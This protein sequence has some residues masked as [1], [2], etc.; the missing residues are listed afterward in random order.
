MVGSGSDFE[1]LSRLSPQSPQIT[2]AQVPLWANMGQPALKIPQLELFPPGNPSTCLAQVW[3]TWIAACEISFCFS[4]TSRHWGILNS[5][6]ICF[7]QCRHL[8]LHI[9]ESAPH[10]HLKGCWSRAM[11]PIQ[12]W[13]RPGKRSIRIYRLLQT[14]KESV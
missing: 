14:K 5:A 13:I 11:E 6:I 2:N 7:T 10:H 3:L 8:L 12:G 4:F 9:Q 1:T